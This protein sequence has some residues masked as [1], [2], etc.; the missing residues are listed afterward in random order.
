MA[1]SKRATMNESDRKW[2]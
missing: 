2:N 1:Q